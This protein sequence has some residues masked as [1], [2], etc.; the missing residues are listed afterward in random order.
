MP[1]I[2]IMTSK[3][4]WSPR[5]FDKLK[6]IQKILTSEDTYATTMLLLAVDQWPP[7]PDDEIQEPLCFQW[8]PQTLRYEIEQTW[9]VQLP[10]E[11]LDKLMAAISI[12]KTD[13]FFK[14][15]DRFIKL[16]NILSGS[17]FD[18]TVFDPADSVECAWGITEALLLSP[19]DEDDPE[20]F[21]DNVRRYVGF[22]LREEGY[23]TAPDILRIALD[24]DF[25]AQVT[26]NW[27]D[28]PE[29]FQGIYAVQQ[30]K[31][32]EVEEIIKGSLLEL[33]GQL[34]ALPL[35]HGD[36]ADIEQRLG[37]TLKQLVA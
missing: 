6:V 24:A 10:Q 23:V 14:D 37:A 18:P 19:P 32:K 5:K 21:S 3:Q 2:N 9:D 20:P 16:C 26:Y 29:M 30:D 31:T 33:L 17:S 28:D 8:T 4:V 36:T 22:V 15:E 35:Q 27:A 25:S 11:N 7:N 34:K 12:V 1:D 13:F